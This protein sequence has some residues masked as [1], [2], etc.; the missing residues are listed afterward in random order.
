MS[1]MVR[2][3]L[4]NGRIEPVDPLPHEW[5][6]GRELRVEAQDHDPTREELE[7]WLRDC[8]ESAGNLTA[9][10]WTSFERALAD[11]EREQK[12]LMRREMGLT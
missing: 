7:R 9:E 2:A 5:N 1:R 11:H 4:K 6:D 10:D 12:E 8:D 3:I